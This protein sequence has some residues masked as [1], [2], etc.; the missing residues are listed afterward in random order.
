MRK[1][2]VLSFLIVLSMSPLFSQ[3][4]EPS[5]D[6][7]G[8]QVVGYIQAQYD[9]RFGNSDGNVITEEADDLFSFNRARM[10]LLGSIPY[11]F[12]YYIIFEFSP[13]KGTPYLLDGFITYSR[14]APMLKMTMGRF[15]SPFGLELN[16]PCQGLYTINRSDVVNALTGPGRDVGLW[17]HGGFEEALNLKYNLALT[18]GVASATEIGEPG[19]LSFTSRVTVEP[20]EMLQIGASYRYT[21]FRDSSYGVTNEEMRS[22]NRIGAELQFEWEDLLVQ[23]EYIMGKGYM[24][25]PPAGAA[26]AVG[27]S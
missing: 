14:F 27:G 11:D 8:V 24:E 13:T 1:I 2:L 17:F 7:E 26:G 23:G 9:Y 12:S 3:C 15:K 25:T 16:T 5:G 18:N 22:L 20:I 19:E 6:D 10:G 4:I 21:T